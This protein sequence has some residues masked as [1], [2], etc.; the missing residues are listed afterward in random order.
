MKLADGMES[1]TRR[2]PPMSTHTRHARRVTA[3][4]PFFRLSLDPLCT[5]PSM[6]NDEAFL[7]VDDSSPAIVYHGDWQVLDLPDNL[8]QS[9]ETYGSTVTYSGT[10]GSY[11]TFNFTGTFLRRSSQAS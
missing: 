6:S 7:L 5:A 9:F 1:A 8:V 3:S 2:C 10:N 4:A 11:A